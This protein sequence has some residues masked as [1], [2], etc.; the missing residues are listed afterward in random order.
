LWDADW[1]GQGGE[2]AG[3]N[4]PSIKAGRVQVPN[5]I[6]KKRFRDLFTELMTRPIK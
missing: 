4:N 2:L 6:D 5:G 3:Q 1:R